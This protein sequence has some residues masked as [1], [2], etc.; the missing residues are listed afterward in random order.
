MPYLCFQFL[1][2]LNKT[3]K[4]ILEVLIL[5]IQRIIIKHNFRGLGSSPSILEPNSNLARPQANLL[6]NLKLP[7]MFELVVNIKAGLEQPKLIRCE[8]SFLFHG[9]EGIGAGKR[10]GSIRIHNWEMGASG[11]VKWRRFLG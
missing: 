3:V 9:R 10:R 11:I 5:R 6:C 4:L 7:V 1:I 2:Q 8:P